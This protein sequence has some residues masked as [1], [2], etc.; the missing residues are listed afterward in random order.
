MGTDAI[1]PA[2]RASDPM[3]ATRPTRAAGLVFVLLMAGVMLA[4]LPQGAREPWS[5]FFALAWV[6]ALIA[7]AGATLLAD[8]RGAA[9]FDEAMPRE[10]RLPFALFAGV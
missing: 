5:A 7:I 6:G 4:P 1:D 10:M 2:A 8:G 9:G 3:K